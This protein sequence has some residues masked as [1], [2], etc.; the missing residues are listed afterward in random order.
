MIVEGSE[1]TPGPHLG[2]PSTPGSLPDGAG[3]A[4]KDQMVDRSGNPMV[5]GAGHQSATGASPARGRPAANRG[6]LR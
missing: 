3:A 2:S 4:P 5:R 1:N 6:G